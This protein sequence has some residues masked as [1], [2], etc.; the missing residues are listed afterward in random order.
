VDLILVGSEREHEVVLGNKPLLQA[1]VNQFELSRA[2]V[3]GDRDLVRK[4][5]FKDD[6][7]RSYVHEAILNRDANPVIEFNAPRNLYAQTTEANI[8]DIF[9]FLAGKDLPVPVRGFYQVYENEIEVTAMGLKISYPKSVSPEVSNANWMLGTRHV[10]E[11]GL[12][13]GLGSERLFS[14]KEGDS[15]LHAQAS[16]HSESPSKEGLVEL[17]K[18]LLENE[19]VRGGDINMLDGNDR[20]WLQGITQ[21]DSRYRMGIAWSCPLQSGGYTRYAVYED[22]LEKDAEAWGNAL[23]ELAGRFQCFSPTNEN[24]SIYAGGG[25]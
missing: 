10:E 21:N 2:G 16:W 22:R 14:W 20:I 23:T 7:L 8:N 18:G 15:E 19:G 12:A 3:M 13:F 1:E 17:L 24:S 5:V 11:E 9:R 4:F 6:E 25:G